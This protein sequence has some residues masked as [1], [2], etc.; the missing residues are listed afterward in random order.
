MTDNAEVLPDDVHNQTLIGN[1]HPSDWHNSE[2]AGRYNLVVIGAGTAGLVAA[3]VRDAARFGVKVRNGWAVDFGA[4]MERMR[5]LRAG[6]IDHDS[7]ARYSQPSQKPHGVGD[8]TQID[9]Q[10]VQL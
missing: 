10:K 9:F 6:I 8:L 7:T 5:K 1:V 3:S 2:P 4:A